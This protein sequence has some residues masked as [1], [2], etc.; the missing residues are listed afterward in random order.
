MIESN[1]RKFLNKA[2]SK[3]LLQKNEKKRTV[4]GFWF[5]AMINQRA[6]TI[7]QYG[8]VRA[9]KSKSKTKKQQIF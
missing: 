3:G 8:I 9:H 4:M 7:V 1:L 6:R 2:R 5:S